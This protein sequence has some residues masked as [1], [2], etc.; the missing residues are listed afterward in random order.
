MNLESV[1]A[2]SLSLLSSNTLFV[3]IF[4]S[5]Q[6][7]I[8]RNFILLMFDGVSIVYIYWCL[9]LSIQKLENAT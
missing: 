8:S 5:D 2:F 9:D 6:F 1:D 7:T 4:V 3:F